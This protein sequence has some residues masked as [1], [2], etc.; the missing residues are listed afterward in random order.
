MENLILVTQKL[1]NMSDVEDV[2][3]LVVRTSP[4]QDLF[5]FLSV[6]QSKNNIAVA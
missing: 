4:S 5:T 2:A 3:V 6:V 1:C